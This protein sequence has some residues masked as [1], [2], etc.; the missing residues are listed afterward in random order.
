MKRKIAIIIVL[1]VVGILGACFLLG[2]D[3]SK[4]TNKNAN[5]VL[6][7]NEISQ[8]ENEELENQ[9]AI[10]ESLL[11][12][13]NTYYSILENYNENYDEILEK[14]CTDYALLGD[15]AAWVEIES[16]YEQYEQNYMEV[17]NLEK[18]VEN[19]NIQIAKLHESIFNLENYSE[20]LSLEELVEL[21]SE[22]GTDYSGNLIGKDGYFEITGMLIMNG[23]NTSEETWK[24]NSRAKKIVV[25]IDEEEY[26]FDLENTM[27]VQLIDFN[28]RQE[29][30][31]TPI[32]IEIKVVDTY[33][34]ESSDDVYISDIRFG[35]N[36]SISGGR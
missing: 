19:I 24:N 35:L 28:Y 3:D 26:G 23:N 36:S 17:V 34:G 16:N 18:Y 4:V 20:N 21:Q 32:N 14:Y 12:Q 6:E 10:I 30:T 15:S 13:R 2:K 9:D 31:D 8:D 1:I 22:E 25:I 27:D 33:E 7:N 5:D 29:S 11:C